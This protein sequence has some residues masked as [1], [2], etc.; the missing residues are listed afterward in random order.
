MQIS[1]SAPSIW[2]R[3]IVGLVTVSLLAATATSWMIYERFVSTN[4]AFRDRTLQNDAS[5][6]KK[7]LQRTAEGR[8]LQLP[9]FLNDGFQHGNGKYAIVSEN[10]VLLAAS[11]GVTAPLAPIDGKMIRDFFMS[12]ADGRGPQLYGFTLKGVFGAKPVWIQIALPQGEVV[13]DSVLEEFIIDIGWIWV[14]FVI[15]L[16]LTNLMV[17]RIGLRPLRLAALQAESIGPGAVSTRLPKEGL[18]RE[19]YALV[20]SVN[21]ALDRLE[22]AF[23]SQQRFIADAAHE[24]RTPIAVIKAHVGILPKSAEIESL[25]DEIR[26]AERL[27][28]QLLDS[29]RLDV[30]VLDASDLVD[31]NQI[32]EEVVVQLGPMAI[33]SGKS[34]EV[35]PCS[36][37][38]EVNGCHDMLACAVRNLV[39]NAIRFTAPATPVTIVVSYPPT[40][41]VRDHGPGV[42]L[43]ERE[44][45][46]K[47]FW[48]GGRDRGGGAGLG[49]DIVSRTVA[50]LGGSVSVGDASGG[51]AVFTLRFPTPG[52]RTSP[53]SLP[54]QDSDTKS[55]IEINTSL[56][57]PAV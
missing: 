29:A 10:G 9:D 20:S 43:E 53:H 39:E 32:V 44:R 31:L 18:P 21:R 41:E 54:R 55:A 34:I 7:L 15:G 45:I 5:I 37:K 36:R 11:P 48:Q 12:E 30:L 14:P 56:H 25:K 22:I 49:L 47:R 24:L 17:A 1:R 19:V 57:K 28:N 38:V 27:V 3:L 8:P 51:G 16:L 2:L 42:R 13:F 33:K 50:A 6:I 23:H 46:F 4:S 52:D 26:A 40:L 35:L